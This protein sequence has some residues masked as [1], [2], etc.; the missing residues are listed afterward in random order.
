MYM[1]QSVPTKNHLCSTID[2]D[3][4][5]RWIQQWERSRVPVYD[6]DV[7]VVGKQRR[8]FTDRRVR[9]RARRE[10]TEMCP[11]ANVWRESKKLK[12]EVTSKT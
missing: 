1:L 4:K 5:G 11:L 2:L 7:G 10:N 8:R 12:T 3:R 9:T 6:S